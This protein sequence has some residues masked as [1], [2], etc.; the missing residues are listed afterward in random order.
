MDPNYNPQAIE[1]KWQKRWADAKLFDTEAV[2]GR[3]KYYVLEMLPYPSGDIHMGHVRN[4]SIGDALARYM[5]MK[6]YNVLHPIGWDAF[7]LPA[8]NA[9]IKS[10][11]HPSEF[12]FSYIDR[13]RGQ[14]Q[15]LGVSYDWRR[16]IASCV[17]EYYRW[18]QWFFLK[19]YERGLA[20]RRKSRV[21]WCPECNT[22]LAN[23]QVVDGCCWRHEETR[24]IER[25]LE[26]WFLKITAYADQLLED[27]REL[28][29]W[30]ER[31]LTMQENWIGKSLGTF[32]D[33]TVSE[34]EKPLRIFTTR[35]DTI[36]GCTAVFLAPEHPLVEELVA[37]S[38][39][40]TRLQEDV[41]R[42]QASSV[43]A[44]VEVNLDKLGADTGFTAR[45]PYN[46][47]AVPIWLAN[48]V[49]MEYGTGA[50]MAVPAHDERDFE[51]CSAYRL[52]VRTVIVPEGTD[53]A[54]W[55]DQPLKAM[56][57]YGRLVASG[58]YTGLTSAEAIE[59]MTRD[60]EAQG[61]GEGT[62]QYRLKDWGISRQRYWGTPIPMVYCDACGI[63]PVAEKDL[64]VILPPNVKLTGRGHSPLADVPEFVRTACSKCAKPARR[65][66]D[67]M[68]TFVDSSWYFYRYTDPTIATAP[69]DKNVV[70]YWFPV[71]QYIGGIEHA[72]LHLIYMRFFTKVM[73]D[74]GLVEFSEPVARLF[75][76]GMVIKDG[77]K[78]SKSK[79]NV[80]DPTEMFAKYGADTTRIY[81]LF[82]APPEKDLDWSDAGIE[83][84]ARFVNRVYRLV[85]K[86]AGK[87][88]SVRAG[89]LSA[90]EKAAL[91]AEERRLL[92]KAH[93]TLRHVTEDMEERWHF[94]TDIAI[95][96]ELVNELSE[97]ET[98]VEA[99]KIRPPAHKTA[100]EF[101][102]IILSLFAPHAADELWEGLGHA[103]PLLK[104]SW[105]AF[106]AELAAEDELELPVQ[107]NGRL[108]ARIRV[109][110]SASEEEIRA[111]AL[112]EDKVIQHTA[113]RQVAKVI[114][115]PQKLVSIVV[116]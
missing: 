23:E 27:M 9:A 51:F 43:R 111:R 113:G 82:A 56:V 88:T 99:G 107:V 45:N 34:L 81:I 105:P 11:R 62:I 73:R 52:P 58:P 2:P 66:T 12:T 44:R 55:A 6:G 40:P 74:I 26:Q 70:K 35:V 53:P 87:L 32:V 57:E 67:T 60:A 18:N 92:R 22:V 37:A 104:I 38:K 10:Q 59:R 30:P 75:T 114:V 50:I 7:G 84:A 68:D 69:V 109:A 85:A 95:A 112:A 21:N 71:D 78:M 48:F 63:V 4:Y 36:F 33:F 80:V 17:P 8:E 25:E 49:L 16:E 20:Y 28:V 93:Q 3:Q 108:R 97:L 1:A 72:I 47:E 65:E 31:V 89:K 115:V 13:M 76:Q 110:V 83:G 64:P 77:A 98:A 42:M 101:L 5:W 90:G 100:L 39:E 86:H 94:N 46:G 24:V 96:M 91:T 106:D 102:V 54:T 41:E 29:R 19:M 14:L 61:F 15:R 103:E 79:G 116:K